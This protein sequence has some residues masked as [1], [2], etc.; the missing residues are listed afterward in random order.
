LL[1][2]CSSKISAFQKEAQTWHINY[3]E[4]SL[5]DDPSNSLGKGWCQDTNISTFWSSEK[6]EPSSVMAVWAKVANHESITSQLLQ[7]L[8]AHLTTLIQQQCIPNGPK[9]NPYPIWMVQSPSSPSKISKTMNNCSYV[10][11]PNVARRE[12]CGCTH[13]FPK[14]INIIING[15]AM[16]CPSKVNLHQIWTLRLN[17]L[18]ILNH[19]LPSNMLLNQST[20]QLSLEI[21]LDSYFQS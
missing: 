1:Q 16:Q 12:A 5:S 19:R 13:T 7:Q 20:M 8:I 10:S 18:C 3:L 4:G 2:L 15:A 21:Y 14:H 9:H 11:C 6:T 17:R